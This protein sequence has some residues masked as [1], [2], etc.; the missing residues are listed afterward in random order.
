[1]NGSGQKKNKNTDFGW[2]VDW[3]GSVS[4]SFFCCM[5]CRLV[6][7]CVNCS[8]SEQIATGSLEV[9]GNINKN[10]RSSFV[11]FFLLCVVTIWDQVRELTDANIFVVI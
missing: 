7:K 1:M 9:V 10:A 4:F 8:P 2:Y 11:V 5:D 6:F 3:S